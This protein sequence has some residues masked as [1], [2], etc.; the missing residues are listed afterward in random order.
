MTEEKRKTLAV[1]KFASCD[2]CQLSLLDC[3]D[4]ILLLTDHIKIAHFAEASSHCERGPYDIA[5]VEG[6]ITTPED[7]QRIRKVRSL[8]TVLV[9][10]GACATAG[11]IQALRNFANIN[12]YIA[13]VYAKPEYIRTLDRSTAIE[14]YVHVDYQL[15]GCPINKQQL[16]ELLNALLHQRKPQIPNHSVCIE[17][18]LAGNA[19]ITVAQGT[20]CLGP[21]THAGCGALCPSYN[22]GCFGCYGPK[23]NAH[24]DTLA[25]HMAENGLD[26]QDI[27]FLLRNFNA[28]AEAFAEV[29]KHYETGKQKDQNH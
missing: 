4:E 29:S 25:Q 11:G 23:E 9:T 26:D 19:C 20:P 24:P 27:L 2:G 6:S 22:R 10:I 12:D 3:E 5:L 28:G 13:T 16:L 15:R 14:A 7:E 17:C 18:K 8:S 21:I 1:F